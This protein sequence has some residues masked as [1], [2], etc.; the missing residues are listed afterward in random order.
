MLARLLTPAACLAAQ[1]T[2]SG[3]SAPQD[4]ALDAAC[5]D[6]ATL[7]DG[8]SCALTCNPGYSLGGAQPSCTGSTFAPGDVS[9]T[10]APTPLPS[11][12]PLAVAQR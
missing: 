1:C 11:R 2:V 3:L 6:E 10:G 9:C 4:G 5:A 8:A 12:G 7:A